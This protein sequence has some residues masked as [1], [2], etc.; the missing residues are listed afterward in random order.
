MTNTETKLFS[1]SLALESMKSSGYRDAAHAV[2]ELIDNSIQANCD[3]GIPMNVEVICVTSSNQIS[4]RSS[5]QISAIAVYDDGTGMDEVTLSS[6]LAFGQ[7][8]RRDAK[9]GMGKF[10]FGLPN[11]SVSQCDRVDVYT[12]Q[13][14]KILHTHLDLSDIKNGRDTVPYPSQISKLPDQ[15]A[16]KISSGKSESGT[17]VVWSLLT[18]LKWRRH[19]AFFSNTEFLVGRMYRYFLENGDCKILMSAFNDRGEIIE[20]RPIR[21]NDPLYLMNNSSAPDVSIGDEHFKFSEHPAFYLVGESEVKIKWNGEKHAVKIKASEANRDFR[22]Y[23]TSQGTNPGDTKFGKHAKRNQGVSIVRENRELELNGSFDTSYN[24]VERFWGLEVSFGRALD[25]VFGVTNNKQSATALNNTTLNE[26]A[27]EEGISQSEMQTILE[28]ESDPRLGVL[29]VSEEV[30]K[31]L[32]TIRKNLTEQT[33]NVTLAK[34]ADKKR[35]AANEAAT[36]A[37]ATDGATS[38]SD[39]DEKTKSEDD[40]KTELEDALNADGHESMT[41]TDKAKVIEAWL[42]QGKFIFNSA[43]IRGSDLIFDVSMPAGK[44]KVTFNTNHPLYEQFIGPIEREDGA[45]YDLL[46]LLFAGWARTEDRLSTQSD[47]MVKQLEDIRKLWGQEANAMLSS[48]LA[49]N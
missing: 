24:P 25:D 5:Q 47:E 39:L 30:G 7:G 6:A 19:K 36:K 44:I 28:S 17:L 43:P 20:S 13:S 32:R 9:S 2:A 34:A 15:W 46:R 1:P 38:K 31:F 8:T 41:D 4:E 33:K 27:E 11:A 40:K 26:L 21:P 29:M 45:S 3:D 10:G 22:R 35:D 12:W 42:S 16:Q 37:A 23:V 48:Y 18:R 49:P 14:D